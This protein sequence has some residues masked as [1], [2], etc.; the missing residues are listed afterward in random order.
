M[1]QLLDHLQIVLQQVSIKS[2]ARV[3]DS[4]QVY[5]AGM[6]EV[7]GVQC[8]MYNCEPNKKVLSHKHSC[9]GTIVQISK[10][11]HCFFDLLLCTKSASTFVMS[12]DHQ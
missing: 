9:H 12:A 5:S 6:L 2:F 7:T 4:H 10:R 8:T 11:Y 3:V 1:L